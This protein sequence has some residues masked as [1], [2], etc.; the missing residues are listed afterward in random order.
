MA[1]P[2]HEAVSGYRV[3]GGGDAAYL[4]CGTRIE[5]GACTALAHALAMPVRGRV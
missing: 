4:A 1:L 3:L 5:G 2:E